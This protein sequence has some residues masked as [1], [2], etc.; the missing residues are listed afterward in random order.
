MYKLITKKKLGSGMAF[1]RLRRFER[2]V[3][4]ASQQK[5]N[6]KPVV[7]ETVETKPVPEAPVVEPTAEPLVEQM[8]IPT[9]PVVEN[10]VEDRP[11]KRNRKKN[12]EQNIDNN[13]LSNKLSIIP[14]DNNINTENN[15]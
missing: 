7:K 13:E 5:K 3:N 14:E 2:K 10:Q 15:E 1:E 6:D 8:E 4:E 9:E 12:I 11:S